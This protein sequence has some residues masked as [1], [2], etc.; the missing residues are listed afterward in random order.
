MSENTLEQNFK[1]LDELTA[2][3]ESGSLPLEEMYN[4]Y[5]EG[6]ELVKDSNKKIDTVEK[7][8]KL[9]TGDEAAN[10]SNGGGE[11]YAVDIEIGGDTELPF[12]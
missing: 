1:R 10:S 2:K 4:L 12:K 9:L 6:I 8:M 3:L 5:K 7:A 11:E